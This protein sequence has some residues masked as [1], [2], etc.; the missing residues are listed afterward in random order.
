MFETLLLA[1][2]NEEILAGEPGAQEMAKRVDTF[3]IPSTRFPSVYHDPVKLNMAPSLP[4]TGNTR[5][6]NSVTL[7]RFIFLRQFSLCFCFQCSVQV[8]PYPAA[9]TIIGENR[10]I[11]LTRLITAV[12][13]TNEQRGLQMRECRFRSALRLS[14]SLSTSFVSR[15]A[16]WSSMWRAQAS[17]LSNR[18]FAR[19]RLAALIRQ[20]KWNFFQIYQSALFLQISSLALQCYFRKPRIFVPS[21]FYVEAL[22]IVNFCIFNGY[23]SAALRALDAIHQRAVFDIAADVLLVTN[24]MQNL[25]DREETQ[26]LIRDINKNRNRAA[27]K[28]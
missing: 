27:S 7:V 20:T 22:A 9:E 8:G 13:G 3:R 15:F 14:I 5:D 21:F 19:R 25:L 23:P 24:A 12:S 26:K 11:V 17:A 1:I 4:P 28:N 6:V 2:Y 10:F 18:I 16:I